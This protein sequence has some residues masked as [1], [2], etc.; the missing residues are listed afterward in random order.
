MTIVAI[1]N[2][3]Y[4]LS[5]LSLFGLGLYIFKTRQDGVSRS[6]LYLLTL[7]FFWCLCVAIIALLPD[8][9]SKILLNRLK[10]IA[11]SFIPASIFYFSLTVAGD[12][13]KI[14]KWL[15]ALI[16]ISP[17]TSGLITLSPWYEHLIGN[18]AIQDFQGQKV[19][20]FSNGPWFA[21]HYFFSR[22]LVVS[23]L[24]TLFWS[25][26]SQRSYHRRKILLLIASI[27]IPFLIDV[28][29]VNY[30]PVFRYLQVVPVSFSLTSLIILISIYEYQTF[31][32]V[33]FARSQIIA[34]LK[35]PCMMWD[36]QKRLVDFN[37]AAAR[38][39]QLTDKDL[40]HHQT[41]ANELCQ[42]LDY[43]GSEG[44]FFQVVTENVRDGRGQEL[45]FFTILSDIT[46]QKNI[47]QELRLQSE[48]RGTIL[49]ILSH[50]LAGNI[51][52]ISMLSE[53]LKSDLHALK[54]QDAKAIAEAIYDSAMSTNHFI[55]DL[56]DWSKTQTHKIQLQNELISP[57]EL[58]SEIL[59]YL[60]AL[61]GYKS[62]NIANNIAPDFQ[63]VADRKVLET[64]MR[65][66]IS[67]AIKHTPEKTQ[68]NISGEFMNHRAT[69]K[70]TDTGPAWNYQAINDFFSNSNKTAQMGLGL[71][72]CR[73]LIRL[74]NGR[75]E[76][77]HQE[78]CGTSFSITLPG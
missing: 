74:Q 54:T 67:N 29:A 16:F 31:E 3:I 23:G 78:G 38:M 6:F 1:I 25:A 45:G 59:D 76:V 62:Q 50:D 37:E 35:E 73:E 14:P 61:A 46:T 12:H 20:T 72:L 5:A 13:L 15:L 70:I 57:R 75:I 9:E 19:L 66:L 27:M 17:V 21:I 22:M 2:S 26:R 77:D 51:S 18:Y 42:R 68:I 65:N 40:G 28:A 63:V 71:H 24:I 43:Q 48:V 30:F 64:I 53:V 52:T 7:M 60:K 41:L 69:L 58:V 36:I 49:N 55:R 47:E 10:L 39:F 34:Q 56:I 32:V 11:V 33:P 8:I 44:R 4:W